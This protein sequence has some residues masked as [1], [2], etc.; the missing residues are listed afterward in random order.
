MGELAEE[1]KMESLVGT[2]GQVVIAKRIRERLVED[3]LEI[4]FAPRP[5][6]GR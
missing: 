6:G 1:S 4:Y 5:I 2:R 3:H